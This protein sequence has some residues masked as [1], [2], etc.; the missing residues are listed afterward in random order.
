MQKLNSLIMRHLRAISLSELLKQSQC[1]S[2]LNLIQGPWL[3]TSTS[4]LLKYLSLQTKMQA[5]LSHANLNPEVVV[6]TMLWLDLVALKK[7]RMLGKPLLVSSRYL[8]WRCQ[9]QIMMFVM[10]IQKQ[11]RHMWLDIWRTSSVNTR[12]R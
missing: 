2:I 7:S 12:N 11:S 9:I 1:K 4:W 10:S 3:A 6:G 8:C 5:V